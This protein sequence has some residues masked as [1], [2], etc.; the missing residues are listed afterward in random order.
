LFVELLHQALTPFVFQKTEF[1][2]V[3]GL[4]GHTVLLRERG[5]RAEEAGGAGQRAGSLRQA[6]VLYFKGTG[7]QGRQNHPQTWLL[8]AGIATVKPLCGLL[9]CMMT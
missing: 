1:L 4:E 5:L 9:G 6:K 2:L 7:M 3:G 8:S